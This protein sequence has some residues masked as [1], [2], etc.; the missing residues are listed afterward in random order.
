MLRFFGK[1]LWRKLLFLFGLSYN[2]VS[3]HS[4]KQNNYC[5]KLIMF[6]QIH[7]PVEK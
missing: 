7:C 6:H 3:K 2:P 1:S 5:E 4:I